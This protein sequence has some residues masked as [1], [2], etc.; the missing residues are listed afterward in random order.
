MDDPNRDRTLAHGLARLAL[1]VNV[2][3]HGLM[4]LPKI[5]QFAETMRQ[6][7]SQTFLPGYLVE[8]AGYG[9]V[10]GEAS[11]GILLVLGLWVRFG[12]SAGL[13]LM[14]LLE[15]GTCVR[16]DWNVAGLQLTYI[17]LYAAL[18]VTR[19]YDR[20]SVDGILRQCRSPAP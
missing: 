1:G 16:Q 7:F 9:I 10:V 13:L 17:A 20:F 11:V 5:G 4:R 19:Q 15:F 6:E 2:A 12:L 14:I 3:L 8:F 18:L